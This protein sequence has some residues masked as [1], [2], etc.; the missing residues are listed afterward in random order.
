[1][2]VP[3][4]MSNANAGDE[5]HL[6]FSAGVKV[7][8]TFRSALYCPTGK[9]GRVPFAARIR[10]FPLWRLKNFP[11][12]NKAG[13]CGQCGRKRAN[14][15]FPRRFC[16]IFATSVRFTTAGRISKSTASASTCEPQHATRNPPRFI[17]HPTA[18]PSTIRKSLSSKFNMPSSSHR[19]WD[20]DCPIPRK[21]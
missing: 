7:R 8:H 3:A 9:C 17:A 15:R 19:G 14:C 12:Q 1:M 13:K 21:R 6:N 20:K 2:A 4:R 11:P 16:T 18:S 5:A 10:S